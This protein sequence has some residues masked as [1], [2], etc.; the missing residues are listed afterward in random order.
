MTI[1]S[2]AV[3]APE[4]GNPWNEELG[5][6]HAIQRHL[7]A[8]DAGVIAHADCSAVCRQ[9]NAVGG[10][11]YD[12]LRLPNGELGIAIGDVAGKGLGAALLMANLQATLR[13]EARRI[14]SDLADVVASVNHLFHQ[15]CFEEGYATLFY[16]TF[17]PE[18]RVLKYLNAGHNPPLLRRA[19][20]SIEWLE[21]GGAP[22]GLFQ[23]WEFQEGSV[24]LNPGDVLVAYTDGIVEAQ[25]AFGEQWGVG[26]LPQIL[27]ENGDQ[28][29]AQI[30]A[31]IWKAVD[32]FAGRAGQADDMTLLVL[33]VV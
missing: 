27:E 11:F 12:F 7:L 15:A 24:V 6:A 18:T 9:A 5:K 1:T 13:A 30:N 20:S 16:A 25:D 21:T 23:S 19:D 17:D 29:A 4:Y 32:R 3:A 31:R 28:T 33:R 10:D 14:P 2:V 22:V 8:P 26:R